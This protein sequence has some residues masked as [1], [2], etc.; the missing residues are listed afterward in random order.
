M[1]THTHTYIYADGDRS[2]KKTKHSIGQ[3]QCGWGRGLLCCPES[4]SE[5]RGGHGGRPG[6]PGLLKVAD[7]KRDK[8]ENKIISKS[9]KAESSGELGA[10]V[11]GSKRKGWVFSQGHPER[12]VPSSLLPVVTGQRVGRLI[13]STQSSGFLLAAGKHHPGIKNN[14]LTDT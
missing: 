11:G 2:M 8:G 10:F 12:W 5:I 6:R 9:P 13:W 7:V 4:P 1:H 14:V 3:C